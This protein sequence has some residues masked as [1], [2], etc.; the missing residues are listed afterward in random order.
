[1]KT[2]DAIINRKSVRTYTGEMISDNDLNQI[3]TT[4][5]ASP[6][7]MGK[8]DSLSLTVITSQDWL[9]R[10]DQNAQQIFN[11][12]QSMLYGAPLFIIVSTKLQETPADKAAYS[13]AA[14]IIENMNIEAVALGIGA[15]HIWG[16]HYSLK[17]KQSA[18]KGNEAA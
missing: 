14:T 12:S 2:I 3:L 5:Y 8:Y 17:S 10:L 16:V 6:V 7:S 1:M 9:Q 13:N 4:A 18:Y 15:C 11:V